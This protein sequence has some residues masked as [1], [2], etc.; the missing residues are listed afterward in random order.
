MATVHDIL[1]AVDTIAPLRLALDWDN[2]GLLLGSPRR[3]VRKVLV[4]LDVTPEVI[5]EAKA[6]GARC[7][8]SHH[9]LTLTPLKR[10]TT[11]TFAG[12]MAV[13][14]LESKIALIASH[15]NLD[16][17]V[18]GLAEHLAALLGLKDCEPLTPADAREGCKLVVFVPDADLAKVQRAIFDAGAG[19]IGAYRECS[20]SARGTGTFL[21]TAKARPA[22]GRRGRREEVAEYRLEV[23]VPEQLLAEVIGAMKAAHSYEE[24]AFDVYA[25]RAPEGGVGVGRIGTLPRKMSLRRLAQAFKKAVKAKAVQ[26]AGKLDGTVQRV[27]V[28]SGSAGGEF[29]AAIEGRCEALLA[30]ELKYHDVLEASAAGMAVVLAGHFES[31]KAGMKTFTNSLRKSL[32]G[33]RFIESRRQGPP[34]VTF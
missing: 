22:V 17:A 19:S 28:C 23:V 27:A 21:A 10:V 13:E 26:V 20:F 4:C 7:I 29:R 9:P 14:L 6:A 33:V 34:L 18:G 32:P 30:G 2:C 15:T 3:R 25:T 5:A 8:V 12:R 31:E 24:P 1:K 11:E 16:A